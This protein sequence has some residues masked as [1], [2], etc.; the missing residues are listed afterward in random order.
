MF[1]VLGFSQRIQQQP[2]EEILAL[3][4]QLIETAVLKEDMRCFGLHRDSEGSGVPVLFTL[5]ARYAYFSDTILVWVPL[6]QTFVAPFIQRCADLICEALRVAVP[7]RGAI[8]AGK[9]VMHRASSTYL[10]KPIVEAARLEAGQNWIG[11]MLGPSTTWP[12]LFAEIEP[13]SIIEYS[14]PMKPGAEEYASPVALDW[15]RRWREMFG[16]CPRTKLRQLDTAPAASR[17]Y[18]SAIDFCDHSERYH[19]WFTSDDK[20]PPNAKLKLTSYENIR[21]A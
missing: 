9:A 10:G 17:Y 21:N 20:L 5:P 1:D 3:Y 18:T 4:Q 14:P 2:L 8:V 11:A 12:P 19:D 16:D 13:R 7:L 15:P 6:T